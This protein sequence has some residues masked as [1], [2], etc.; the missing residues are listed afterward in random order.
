MLSA[1]AAVAALS[2]AV[3]FHDESFTSSRG[4]EDSSSALFQRS[5]RP[6]VAVRTRATY[7]GAIIGAR[8]PNA[9][10]MYEPMAAIHSSEFMPIGT[11]TSGNVVPFTGPVRP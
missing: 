9:L 2:L 4:S 1:F 6:A 3:V 5:F 11:M 7:A 10:R 8:L